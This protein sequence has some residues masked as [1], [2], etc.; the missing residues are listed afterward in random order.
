MI[1][2]TAGN[3]KQMERN[4]PDAGNLNHYAIIHHKKTHTWEIRTN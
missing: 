2:D 1:T 3:R 4:L